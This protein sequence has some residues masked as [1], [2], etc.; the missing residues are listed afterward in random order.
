MVSIYPVVL[1]IVFWQV[2]CSLVAASN[3]KLPTYAEATTL[4]TYEEAERSKFQEAQRES[5]RNI[6]SQDDVR[7][8][9]H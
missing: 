2:S 9:C 4:P 6:E 3:Q 1:S 8:I 7:V 5:D